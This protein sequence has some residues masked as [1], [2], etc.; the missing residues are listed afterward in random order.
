MLPE[1]RSSVDYLP[2]KGVGGRAAL[3]D[4]GAMNDNHIPGRQLTRDRS[5]TAPVT[6]RRAEPEDGPAVAEV[7][8]RSFDAALPTVRRAHT[9]AGVRAFFLDVVTR[10]ETWVADENGAVI[11]LMVL[12]ENRI[13][14]LYLA[15]E[16][17]GRGLG[18]RFV[19]IAKENSPDGLELL[20]FQVNTPAHRFYERHGFVAAELTDGS[21]NEER[22]PDIRYVWKGYAGADNRP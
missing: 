3:C 4:I 11:G 2:G 20:T 9:D 12:E 18:D 13:E 5:T 21:E 10:H 14:Q 19:R 7:Y 16:H 8:I 6:L 15:P 22:E 17:R 1:N